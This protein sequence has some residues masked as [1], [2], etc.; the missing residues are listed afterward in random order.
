MRRASRI[1]GGLRLVSSTIKNLLTTSD[2][3]RLRDLVLMVPL[4]RRD[5]TRPASTGAVKNL[6]RC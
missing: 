4:V 5:Q 2:A 1:S 3:A 6:Y